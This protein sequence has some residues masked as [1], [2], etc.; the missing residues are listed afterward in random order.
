MENRC[1]NIRP[2]WAAVLFFVVGVGAARKLLFWGIGLQRPSRS[3]FMIS[4]RAAEEIDG[5]YA[6]S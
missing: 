3:L 4:A 1:G 6:L 2:L 5:D